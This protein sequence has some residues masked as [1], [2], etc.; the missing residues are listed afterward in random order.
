ELK[1]LKEA[2]KKSLYN[3]IEKKIVNKKLYSAQGNPLVNI[4]ESS[5]WLNKGNITP[6]DEAS[7]CNMQD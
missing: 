4:K 1:T 2:Q 5:T 6:R 3:E 7:F